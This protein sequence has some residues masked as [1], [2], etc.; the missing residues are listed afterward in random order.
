MGRR[1]VLFQAE[2][3]EWLASTPCSV[4][5]AEPPAAVVLTP[6]DGMVE[7]V[8]LST[9]G[10]TLFYCNNIGDIE[11]RHVWKVPTSGGEAVQLTKGEGIETYPAA[12]RRASR[13]RC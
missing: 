6:G 2:P 10:R 4:G 11:R 9:D 12:S 8:A 1:H 3:G 7:N 13:W 5:G